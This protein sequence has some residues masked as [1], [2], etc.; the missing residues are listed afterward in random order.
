MEEDASLA[1]L[2]DMTG[3][4]TR[5][6]RLL[7]EAAGGDP[8][9]AAALHFEDSTLPAL[10]RLDPPALAAG[11]RF[12]ALS[13]DEDDHDTVPRVHG[14]SDSG[15]SDNEHALPVTQKAAR[16]RRRTP[17]SSRGAPALDDLFMFEDYDSLALQEANDVEVVSAEA[18]DVVPRRRRRHQ[19]EGVGGGGG[20]GLSACSQSASIPVPSGRRRDRHSRNSDSGPSNSLNSPPSDGATTPPPSA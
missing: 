2:L 14:S 3:L 6:A 10:P 8:A 11:S 4:D 17:R 9:L 7:L 5:S 13:A 12:E 1:F 19:S 15:S 16:G 18:T 20:G